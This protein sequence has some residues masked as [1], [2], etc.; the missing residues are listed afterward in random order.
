MR[1][2][3]ALIEHFQQSTD[4]D[5]QAIDTRLPPTTLIRNNVL[6]TFALADSTLQSLA[7]L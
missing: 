3:E 1:A 6:L 4:A 7:V 5:R 2:H